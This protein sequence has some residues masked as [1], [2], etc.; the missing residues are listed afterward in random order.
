MLI[1]WFGHASF[2]VSSQDTRIITDPYNTGHGINLGAINESADIVT[3][4]HGHGDHNNSASIKGSPVILNTKV[5]Q[6]VKG[7]EIRSIPAFHDEAEGSK[8]GTNLMFC[9]KMNGISLCHLGDLG[10]LLN[11]Q[12][13]EAIGKVDIIFIPVGGFYTI[14]A[15][16][17][18]KV[19]EQL[20]PRLVFPMHFKV[21]KVD[22]PISPV[23]DFIR[24]KKNVKN[25]T[26]CEIDVSAGSLPTS[27]EIVVLQ[28]AC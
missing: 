5:S 9:F 10:H 26:S 3:V 24:N 16:E 28:T 6:T 8:R 25:V 2:L 27:T 13:V 12:Q 19:I 20:K 18:D 17:A 15:S 4:S 1:K 11:S 7:I 21:A 23:D 22:Y 14:D